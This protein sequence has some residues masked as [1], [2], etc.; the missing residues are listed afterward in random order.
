MDWVILTR[1]SEIRLYA[2]RADTGV[3]RKGRAETFVE[4]N[5]SLLPSD[6][7]GYLHLLF[8]SDALVDGGTLEK[9]LGNSERFAAGLASRLR[10]RVY[11]DVVPGLARA[12]AARLGRDRGV[13]VLDDA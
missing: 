12:V 5:L 11:Y 10:E 1:A 6:L 7:A 3:G 8:S 4:L 9:V 2:A 13:E